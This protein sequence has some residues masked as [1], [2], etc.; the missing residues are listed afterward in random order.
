L[1]LAR[2]Q[3]KK[4]AA[5]YS[6]EKLTY[7]F[8]PDSIDYAFGPGQSN[9]KYHQT[10]ADQ[11]ATEFT[12]QWRK[13][14]FH[15]T[16]IHIREPDTFGHKFG[17]MSHQYLRQAVPIAD[18]AI[19]KIVSSIRNSPQAD[20]TLVIITADHGGKDKSHWYGFPEELTIPWIAVH[21]SLPPETLTNTSVN[22]TDTAPTILY[23]LGVPIPAGIDGRVIQRFK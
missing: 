10:N 8:P 17:W 20:S 7:L 19:G 9:I 15:L 2:S 5:F 22:I 14:D 1:Q 12:R 21:S 16:F 6:K 3:G 11:L 23:L 18:Q 4:T 13:Q